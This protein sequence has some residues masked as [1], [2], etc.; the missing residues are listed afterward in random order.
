VCAAGVLGEVLLEHSVDAGTATS[1]GGSPELEE[2][3][4]DSLSIV[5]DGLALLIGGEGRDEDVAEDGGED[6]VGG[7][8]VGAA[9][10]KTAERL[11]KGD[12]GN[13]RHIALLAEDGLELTNV[14]VDHM[15]PKAVGDG[16][17][18]GTKRMGG[19]VSMGSHKG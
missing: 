11:D 18:L 6:A 15:I 2:A 10:E 14:D 1:V 7:L 9:G 19:S 16:R 3:V 4:L 5:G 12:D 13:D 8:I 17:V